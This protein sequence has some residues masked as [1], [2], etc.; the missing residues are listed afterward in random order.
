MAEIDFH[1][2]PSTHLPPKTGRSLARS[3]G[4]TGI[5]R[6]VG[7][8][9]LPTPDFVVVGGRFQSNNLHLSDPI[10]LYCTVLYRTYTSHRTLIHRRCR[11]V[12]KGLLFRPPRR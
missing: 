5:D 12:Q 9:V 1:T 6:R 4:A 2:H 7:T 10:L 11:S 3:L 8:D